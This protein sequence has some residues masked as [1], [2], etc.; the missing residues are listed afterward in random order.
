MDIG[1]RAYCP[2]DA[3]HIVSEP[4]PWPAPATAAQTRCVSLCLSSLSAM[5]CEARVT[6]S[7]CVAP[8][9]R[10]AQ[11][12]VGQPSKTTQ[13]STV[14]VVYSL[15]RLSQ[16]PMSMG[17]Q[18]HREGF[19]RNAG[20][21]S[22]L[23]P[24]PGLHLPDP[25]LPRSCPLWPALAP[26]SPAQNRP[27]ICARCRKSGASTTTIT[28]TTVLLALCYLILSPILLYCHCEDHRSIIS[29]TSN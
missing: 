29:P 24:P 3:R 7:R 12:D 4:T 15:M 6:R 19:G 2:S 28:T 9:E 20:R 23:S 18:P 22:L 14:F 26:F 11:R 8:A 16:S 5:A 17:R 10:A 25:F 27:D 1:S 13:L 21:I